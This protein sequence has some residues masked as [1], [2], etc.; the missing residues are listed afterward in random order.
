VPGR[1]AV[2]RTPFLLTVMVAP[3]PPTERLVPLLPKLTRTPGMMRTDLRN[4]NEM[5]L[6]FVLALR[7]QLGV[8]AGQ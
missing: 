7:R 3:R 6:S 8:A 5:A 2:V 1:L 4:L